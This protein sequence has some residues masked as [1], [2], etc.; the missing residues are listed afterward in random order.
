MFFEPSALSLLL[1]NSLIDGRIL[2]VGLHL[3]TYAIASLFHAEN[4]DVFTSLF[5]LQKTMDTYSI[6]ALFESLSLHRTFFLTLV[7]LLFAVSRRP[8]SEPIV[9][10][11]GVL[12]ADGP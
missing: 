4:I 8:H 1:S 5:S 7:I 11:T 2:S 6:H 3:L 12:A 10:A 9:G